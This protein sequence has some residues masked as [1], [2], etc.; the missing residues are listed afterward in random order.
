MKPDSEKDVEV[1]LSLVR[2]DE[3]IDTLLYLAAPPGFDFPGEKTFTQDAGH[4]TVPNYITTIIPIGNI[5]RGIDQPAKITIKAPAR[6]GTF[7]LCH[8]IVCSGFDSGE[9]WFRVVVK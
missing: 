6:K 1:C 9:K 4:P 2:G 8:R 7:N 5:K 3:S